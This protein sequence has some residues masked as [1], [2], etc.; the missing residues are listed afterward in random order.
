MSLGWFIALTEPNRERTAAK[1]LELLGCVSY[2]PVFARAHCYRS[3]GGRRWQVSLRP[4]FPGYLFVVPGPD[5]FTLVRIA[6]GIRQWNPFLGH[7]GVPAIVGEAKIKEIQALE[8]DINLTSSKRTRFRIGDR[9]LIRDGAFSGHKATVHM[10]SDA[11]RVTLLLDFLGRPTKVQLG[12]DQ[13]G[14][15]A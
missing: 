11:E 14:A 6:V 15:A 10:L 4:L 7:E 8:R 13:I 1:H 5:L 2:L 9:V 3:R 12:A